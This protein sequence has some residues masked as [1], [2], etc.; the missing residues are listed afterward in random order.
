MELPRRIPINVPEYTWEAPPYAPK[1][2]RVQMYNPI[3]AEKRA[4]L[5]GAFSR[6][7]TPITNWTI[8]PQSDTMYNDY[9]TQIRPFSL[10]EAIRSS[11]VILAK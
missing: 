8:G 10:E 6:I 2:A 4:A 9:S 3:S 11:R 1:S 5:A 7:I